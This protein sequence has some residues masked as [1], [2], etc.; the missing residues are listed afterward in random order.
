VSDCPTPRSLGDA[1]LQDLP[2][3]FWDESIARHATAYQRK[4]DGQWVASTWRDFYEAAAALACWLMD[5]GLL[6]RQDRS[7]AALA[8]VVH[9]GH[10]RAAAGAV[11]VSI[12]PHLEQLA[13][14]IEHGLRFVI[15]EDEEQLAKVLEHKSSC[16]LERARSGS[17]A[18]STIS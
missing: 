5:A 17:P 16:Q 14:I 10:R 12:R 1:E 6:W 4:L 18:G 3:L 9:R 7:S 13:Y 2:E 11:T 8:R 15:V